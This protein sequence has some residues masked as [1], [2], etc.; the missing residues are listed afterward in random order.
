MKS[1]G[2]VELVFLLTRARTVV[3]ELYNRTSILFYIKCNSINV[4]EQFFFFLNVNK[5]CLHFPLLHLSSVNFYIS[6]SVSKTIITDGNR[7]A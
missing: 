4:S 5:N 6:I 7:V 2:L 3:N 1:G